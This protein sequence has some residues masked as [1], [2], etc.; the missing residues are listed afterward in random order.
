MMTLLTT[1]LSLNMK[2]VG[3]PQSRVCTPLEL[4]TARGGTIIH[5]SGLQCQAA[6]QSAH[7]VRAPACRWSQSFFRQTGLDRRVLDRI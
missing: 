1:G 7:T 6:V 3:S 5:Q 4:M 2:S